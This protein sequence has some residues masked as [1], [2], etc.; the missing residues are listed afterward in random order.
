MKNSSCLSF[1]QI[2]NIIELIIS[3]ANVAVVIWVFKSESKNTERIR[4]IEKKT[5]WYSM[6]GISDIAKTFSDMLDSKRDEIISVCIYKNK[7]KDTKARKQGIIVNDISKCF[8]NYKRNISIAVKCFD[9][10]I[11]NST[12]EQCTKVE[13]KISNLFNM[14]AFANNDADVDRSIDEIKACVIQLCSIIINS[15]NQ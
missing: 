8:R 10:K 5:M 1:D 4:R 6:L 12:E 7:N 15:D 3:I 11:V 14:F 9:K 2:M 13:D